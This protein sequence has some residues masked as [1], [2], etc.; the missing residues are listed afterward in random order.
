MKK[1]ELQQLIRE[2][3]QELSFGQKGID[4]RN[5][6]KGDLMGKINDLLDDAEKTIGA[7]E[8]AGVINVLYQRYR[9]HL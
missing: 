6:P 4:P 3:L 9:K 7:K 8:V 2:E 1:S 5:N